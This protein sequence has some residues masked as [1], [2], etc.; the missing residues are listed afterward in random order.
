MISGRFAEAGHAV[1]VDQAEK[2]NQA[3]LEFIIVLYEWGISMYAH[4]QY[5]VDHL[6]VRRD[7]FDNIILGRSWSSA[8]IGRLVGWT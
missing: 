3:L 7:D 4:R 1:C 6:P 2:F 5:I 8:P